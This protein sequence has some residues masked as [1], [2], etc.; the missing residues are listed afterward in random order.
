MDDLRDYRFYERDKIHPS[1]EARDY[2]NQKFSDRYFK[3]ETMNLIH[4]LN[5]IQK[6]MAHKPFQVASSPHQAFLKETLRKLESIQHQ[7]PVA[8]EIAH[9]RA[10][11]I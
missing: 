7:V 10:Q 6:A 3:P 2:I 5:E 8:S 11:L 9:V 1:A 4:T